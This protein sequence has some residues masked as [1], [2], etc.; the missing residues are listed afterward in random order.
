MEQ[1]DGYMEQDKNQ[2][3]YFLY[4]D[5]NECDVNNG[6]CNQICINKPGSRECKCNNG[7]KLVS[8]KETCSGNILRRSDCFIIISINI[9]L[10][11]FG[12]TIKSGSIKWK[13]TKKPV[14]TIKL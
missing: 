1:Q 2:Q 5:I 7:Y 6:R 8:D 10:S 4:L 12:S 3:V 9:H 14:K 13:V 11:N